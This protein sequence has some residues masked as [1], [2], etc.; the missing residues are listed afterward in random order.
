MLPFSIEQLSFFIVAVTGSTG[1]CLIK[2]LAQVEQSRCSTISCCCVKCQR[3][4]PATFEDVT[5]A[6]AAITAQPDGGADGSA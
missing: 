1:M 3:A 6:P 2:F 5:V 4:V